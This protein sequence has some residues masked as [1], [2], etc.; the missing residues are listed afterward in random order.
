MQRLRILGN[1][2]V[3]DIGHLFDDP[4][5]LTILS[6]PFDSG[7]LLSFPEILTFST[8]PCE[9]VFLESDSPYWTAKYINDNSM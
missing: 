4:D 7:H 3:V 2:Y 9:S 1:P 6:L 5:I 8:L